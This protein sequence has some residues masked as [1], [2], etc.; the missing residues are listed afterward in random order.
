MARCTN[1]FK[2]IIGK[3]FKNE[4]PLMFKTNKIAMIA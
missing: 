4:I 1:S 2:D 3:S